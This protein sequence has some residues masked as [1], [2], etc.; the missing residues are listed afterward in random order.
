MS[1]ERNDVLND[2]DLEKVAGGENDPES[3]KSFE[4]CD[5]RQYSRYAMSEEDVQAHKGAAVTKYDTQPKKY[6]IFKTVMNSFKV[7]VIKNF[8]ANQLAGTMNTQKIYL[9]QM[10]LTPLYVSGD[11]LIGIYEYV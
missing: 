7:Y 2:E 9:P 3:S 1:E 6:Y 10:G 11:I 8:E 4:Y 5:L